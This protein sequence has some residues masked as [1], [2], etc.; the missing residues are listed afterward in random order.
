MIRKY[1]EVPK[2]AKNSIV[3]QINKLIR[4]YGNKEVRLVVIRLFGKITK[5]RQL[6]E[7]IES[8][9]AELKELK[10]KK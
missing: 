2:R 10:H 6:E 7:Q 5:K 9:E 3:S 8:R 1:N 4:K